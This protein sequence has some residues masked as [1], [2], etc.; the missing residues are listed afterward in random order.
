MPGPFVMEPSIGTYGSGLSCQVAVESP[1]GAITYGEPDAGE[2][3]MWG[4]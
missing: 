4:S 1:A 3:P 2:H